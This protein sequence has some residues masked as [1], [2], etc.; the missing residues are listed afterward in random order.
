MG[1]N[2]LGM[3]TCVQESKEIGEDPGRGWAA[4]TDNQPQPNLTGTVRLQWPSVTAYDGA[5][6]RKL[7]TCEARLILAWDQYTQSMT[8][9]TQDTDCQ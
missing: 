3:K 4:R 7:V 8:R 5:R 2:C 9:Q 6:V 1:K